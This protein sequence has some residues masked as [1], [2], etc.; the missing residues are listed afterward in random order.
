MSPAQ[1]QAERLSLLRTYIV[2]IVILKLYSFLTKG[3]EPIT[4][5]VLDVFRVKRCIVAVNIQNFDQFSSPE[6]V[7][8]TVFGANKSYSRLIKVVQNLLKHCFWS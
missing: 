6:G 4:D 8:L 3:D 2:L 1:A 5:L 7:I